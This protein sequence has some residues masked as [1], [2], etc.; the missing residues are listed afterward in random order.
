MRLTMKARYLVGASCL[1]MTLVSVPAVFAQEAPAQETARPQTG[2]EDI[3]VTANRRT[4]NVQDV[5]LSITAISSS[6]IQSERIQST[7]DLGRLVPTITDAG[8]PAVSGGGLT[9]RGIRG[10]DRSAG[11]DPPNGLFVDGVYF[12]RPEDGDALLFDVER[13]E[14]LRG[15][16]GTLFGK[17]VVGGAINVTTR[18]PTQELHATVIGTYGNYNRIEGQAVVSGP[19]SDTIAASLAVQSQSSDGYARNVITGNDLMGTS[20][21]AI[22]GRVDFEV[23]PEFTSSFSANYERVRDGGLASYQVSNPG[24]PAIYYPPGLNQPKEVSQNID[25]FR[26]RNAFSFIATQNYQGESIGFKSITAYRGSSNHT[27]YDVDGSLSPITSQEQFD[28]YRQFS[29]ELQ[30]SSP[31]DATTLRWVAGLYY[32][33]ATTDQLS[34]NIIRPPDGTFVNVLNNQ[35][36]FGPGPHVTPNSQDVLTLNYAAFGQATLAITDQL[37]LTAGIRYTIEKKKGMSATFG[38]RD[39][40][41]FP[42]L[43][44]LP[45]PAAGGPLTG[46]IEGNI[47]RTWKAW[48]PRVAIDY[49]PAE[50]I[51]FYASASRGFKGGGFTGQNGSLATISRTFNPEF[52]WNYELGLRSRFLDNRAQV[53]AT[54]YQMDYSNLQVTTIIGTSRVTDNAADARIRGAEVETEFIPVEGLTTSLSYAYTDAKYRNYIDG[55]GR[56]LSGNKF[57]GVSRHVVNLRADYEWDVGE[58]TLTLSGGL[59]YRSKRPNNSVNSPE[60]TVAPVTTY[61]ASLAYE[62]GSVELRLWARNLTNER[63]VVTANDVTAF[64]YLSPTSANATTSSFLVNYSAPRTFGITGTW[65]Y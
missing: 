16:Q 34:V 5:P 24:L 62:K 19:L 8:L 2:I 11:A 42:G 31:E 49:S 3:V 21:N 44:E 65:R 39:V 4:E 36:G 35:L 48:T 14:V 12:G 10:N 45:L 25:G 46:R 27:L 18:A 33:R 30:L 29:Q 55:S 17:N 32:F 61:D 60:V 1:G 52:A 9:I 57:P 38:D 28:R 63:Y 64:F 6:D 7:S 50:D 53:N 59:T 22:R 54:L 40:S 56:N 13:I 15:P 20:R 26:N 41:L 43:P 37:N 51:M 23:T 58:G 47:D